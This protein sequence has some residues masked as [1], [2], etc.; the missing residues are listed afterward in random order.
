MKVMLTTIFI[1][2]Q[3]TLS[4]AEVT[5]SK[6]Y[7]FTPSMIETLDRLLTDASQRPAEAQEY[8]AFFSIDSTRKISLW[9]PPHQPDNNGDGCSMTFRL[10]G[11]DGA[12]FTIKKSLSLRNTLKEIHDRLATIDPNSTEDHQHF[13]N[14]FGE[15]DLSGSHYFCK[16]EGDSHS[17]NWGCYLY[18]SEGL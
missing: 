16:P 5:I 8:P 13:G 6:E 9:C 18:V 4:F 12:S 17:K 15:N 11:P 7:S 1:L 3:S 2:I 10:S 14:L